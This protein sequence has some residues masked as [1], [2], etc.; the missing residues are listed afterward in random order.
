MQLFEPSQ[1]LTRKGCHT[2]DLGR[3]ASSLQCSAL[4]DI[5]STQNQVA[6]WYYAPSAASRKTGGLAAF[7][8]P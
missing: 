6:A 4:A 3:K 7:T 8:C 2:P 5:N 1:L